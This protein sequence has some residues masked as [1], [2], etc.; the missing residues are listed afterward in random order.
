MKPVN[1]Q[2]VSANT[3]VGIFSRLS[4]KITY[5][6]IG[7]VMIPLAILIVISINQTTKTMEETYSTYAM[8]LAEEAAV[9]IDFATSSS[10][11]TYGNYAYNLAQEAA[12]A[13]NSLQDFGKDVYLNY[14]KNLAQEAVVGI[15]SSIESSETV[16]MHHAQNLAEETV[17]SIDLLSDLGGVMSLLLGMV[18]SYALMLFFSLLAALRTVNG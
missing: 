6:I 13:I 1:G 17:I 9:G 5:L 12:V 18:G 14:A 10:E 4:T 7:A 11:G 8:N 16:Y 3:K 2:T 15:N